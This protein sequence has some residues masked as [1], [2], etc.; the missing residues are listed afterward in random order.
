MEIEMIERKTLK[1]K[2][3]AGSELGFGKLFTDYMFSMVYEEGRGW[4][5]AKISPYEPIPFDPSTS[6]LHYAQGV[7]EGA[8]AFKNEKGEIRIFRLAENFSRM[9]RSCDRM[10]MPRLDADFAL[11]AVYR[12]VQ[13]EKDWIP[14]AEGTALYIR[15]LM[16]ASSAELGVHAAKKYLFFVILSPVGAYYKHGLAPTKIYVENHYARTVAGG[17][18]E[19]KCLGNYA[20]SIKAAEEA[21]KKG[22]D[23]VLWLDGVHKKYIE[24]VGSMNIFFVISG[25]VVTPMLAGSILP[26]I[27]RKSTIELLKARGYTVEERRVSVDEVVKAAEDGTLNEIF[28]T[29]TAAVVS[30]VGSFGYN[31]KDYTVGD[32]QMGKITKYVYDELTGIQTGVKPDEFGWVERIV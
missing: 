8:K 18:G 9:N 3:A 20:G 28:G 12:L 6:V 11:K 14:T 13:L 1:E 26:G 7:F 24:E 30:P 16:I 5:D 19:A 2:P 27:T 32:G 21:Q 4:H 25:V 10:C 22:Y 17:T 29:G 15:P 31:G 23:Q